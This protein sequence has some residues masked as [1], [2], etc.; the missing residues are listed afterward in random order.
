MKNNF[1]IIILILLIPLANIAL[2]DDGTSSNDVE[3]IVSNEVIG[4]TVV[5]A[6]S[7]IVCPEECRCKRSTTYILIIILAHVIFLTIGRRLWRKYKIIL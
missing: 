2:A 3:Q 7:E 1:V 5:N 4:E 6:E